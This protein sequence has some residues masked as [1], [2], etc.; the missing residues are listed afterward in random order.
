MDPA[1]K[2][3]A[4]WR[5]HRLHLYRLAVVAAI[6]VIW[7]GLVWAKVVDPL[8]SSDPLRIARTISWLLTDDLVHSRLAVTGKCIA[9]AFA[10]GSVLGFVIGCAFGL[11]RLIRA[12]FYTPFLFL[13]STPKVIF[14][15]F[16]ILVFGIGTKAAIAFGAFETLFYVAVNVVGGLDL[17]EGR[18]LKVAHAFRASLLARMRLVILPAASPGLFAALWMGLRHAFGGVLIMELIV[19]SGGVGML[20]RQLTNNIQPDRTMAL[21]LFICVIAILA[22]T[23]WNAIERR[24]NRWRTTGTAAAPSQTLRS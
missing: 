6:L 1:S 23:G 13:M 2:P 24:A 5:R 10:L 21:I 11:S 8:L 4:S 14:T 7:Q 15:P 16:F 3:H 9:I 22:G 19:S 18:H 12:A 20:V 17:V